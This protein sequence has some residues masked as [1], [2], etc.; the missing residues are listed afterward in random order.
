MEKA[1][2]GGRPYWLAHPELADLPRCGPGG[3]AG[4]NKKPDLE[5]VLAAAPQVIFVTYM[6]ARLADAVQKTLGV[7][8]VVLSYGAFATFD[9]AVYDALCLA[10]SV[11][12]RSKRADTVVGYI[13]TLRKDLNGRTE[14]LLP[15][16]KP[17]AYV[18]GIGYRGAHG[19]ESSEQQYA[20]PGLGRGKKPGKTGQGR[21]RQPRCCRH[22]DL[23][24]LQPG[25]NFHRR[26]R[27][28]PGGGRLP[29]KARVYAR[30]QAFTAGRVHVLLPF[31]WYT[32]NIG[33][34]LADAYAVGKILYPDRFNDVDPK[35]KADEIYRFLVG[36]PVYRQMEKD[37]GAVGHTAPFLE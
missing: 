20:P 36:K 15:E 2:P 10:G 1:N 25:S 7:P 3:P 23:A 26:R 14:S 18:G 21:G 16:E 22:G 8:V 5:A 37:Y 35:H 29:K 11:L 34:A 28:E 6:K 27:P 19:I 9:E 17:G 24:R 33:T 13:E 4:I 12:N 31:N 32:T 30:L